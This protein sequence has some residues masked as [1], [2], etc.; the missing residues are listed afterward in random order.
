MNRAGNRKTQ[1]SVENAA[2]DEQMR[3]TMRKK[4]TLKQR[5]VIHQHER[6]L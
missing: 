5:S 4:L 2:L 1:K 6:V 3:T